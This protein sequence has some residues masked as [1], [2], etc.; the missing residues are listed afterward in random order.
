[1]LLGKTSKQKE[2]EYQ[3]ELFR[4][5]SG[6]KRFAFLPARLE[7]GRFVWLRTYWEYLKVECESYTP[8]FRLY[9]PRQKMFRTYRRTLVHDQQKFASSAILAYD[10]E[11]K[12]KELIKN[13]G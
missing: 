11:R 1:M 3:E 6:V 13:R 9:A 8:V 12:A 4:L 2:Q 7:D 5:G 10:A